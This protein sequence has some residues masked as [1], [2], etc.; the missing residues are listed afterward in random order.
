MKAIISSTYDD[1]YLFFLPIVTWCWN[2]LGVDVICFIPTIS[3]LGPESI[4]DILK[5]V[6][7]LKLINT[8]CVSKDLKIESHTFDAPYDKQATYAQCSRLYAAALPN[9]REGEIICTSDV[10]MAV[11][12]QP[13]YNADMYI[14]GS[15][16][17]PEGQYPMCYATASVKTWKMLMGIGDTSVQ[18][19]LDV[20]LGDI[21]CE[22]MR[23]NY[24]GK[25]QQT[26]WEKSNYF[27]HLFKRAR[28][29]TQF[30]SHRC[31]RDDTNWRSYLG[32]DLVDAHLWRP[33]YTDENFA[34][35]LELLQTQYPNDSFQWLIDY[36]NEYI[37]L[38]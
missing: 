16:L 23:G 24:W 1:K 18:E 9:L 15:D 33:G 17:V 6:N 20:L 35:I 28:P 5:I 4:E 8:V 11:F 10:D 7:K 36:H 19:C 37:K 3:L 26:L 2:K 25:D 38:L 13:L 27:A 14:W 29:G 30:A 21:E 22:N 34:N 12:K 31:D 32:S